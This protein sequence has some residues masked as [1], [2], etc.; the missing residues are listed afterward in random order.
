MRRRL[1]VLALVAGLLLIAVGAAALHRYG[2]GQ[3][4]TTVVHAQEPIRIIAAEPFNGTIP[5]AIVPPATV[6]VDT[7]GLKIKMPELNI[8]LD[9]IEGDGVEAPLYRAAHYPGT[10]WPGQGGRTVLY[11]HARVGM[12]GPLFGA[13]V[14]QRIQIVHAGGAIQNYD[15]VEYYP[16]WPNTDVRWLRATDYEELVLITCTTYNQNDPKIIVVARPA[17]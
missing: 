8:N 16:S 1:L 6:R 7:Q 13:R 10:A 14:G 3:P 15:I 9:I 11:A 17:K 12:F 2:R 5:S 4:A